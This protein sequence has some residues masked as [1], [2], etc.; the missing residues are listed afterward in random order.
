M[1]PADQG[2]SGGRRTAS[3]I[4]ILL[5]VGASSLSEDAESVATRVRSPIT[6]AAPSTLR[7]AFSIAAFD[8]IRGSADAVR[9][10]TGVGSGSDRVL[11]TERLY[12]ARRS[13]TNCSTVR[14]ASTAAAGI[15]AGG[16]G[17][18]TVA[19]VTFARFTEPADSRSS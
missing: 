5:K 8:G 4:L 16:G 11:V 10:R 15:A 9:S 14:G 3:D 18:T 17:S 19:G 13:A 6:A 7:N 1:V 12:S 2:R